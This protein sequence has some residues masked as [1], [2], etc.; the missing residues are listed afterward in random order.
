MQIGLMEVVTLIVGLLIIGF[1][2]LWFFTSL[3]IRQEQNEFREEMK[4]RL[5]AI[6]EALKRKE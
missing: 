5:D 3:G 2:L 6:I 1:F 4:W